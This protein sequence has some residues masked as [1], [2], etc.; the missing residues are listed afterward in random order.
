MWL[1][2]NNDRVKSGLIVRANT[3]FSLLPFS[4]AKY[5]LFLSK[6]VAYQAC[7]V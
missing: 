3:F 6:L 1:V 4:V 2:R 7:C 5:K